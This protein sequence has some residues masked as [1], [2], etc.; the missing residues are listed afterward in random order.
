MKA[1]FEMSD[2]GNLS[3]FLGIEFTKT[4]DGIFMHQR[5]YTYDVLERFQMNG[6][7][8]VSTPIEVG[9]AFDELEEDTSVDKTLDRQ[10]IGCHR[11][12]CNTRPN[13]AYG[14]GLVSR[15]MES[16]KKSNLL[17]ANRILKYVKGTIGHGLMLPTK[18]NNINHNMLGF[19]DADWCIDKSDKKS[20]TSY[21][22]MLGGAPI[23]WCSKKRRC[24]CI[25]LM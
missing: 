16:S 13:I 8:L 6:C 10:M 5:K 14:V 24:G 18:A 21:M 12:V 1:E 25:V 3:Y 19:S 22:F 9:T 7:N 15:Y 20:T 2:L 17:T 11:Y 4:Y 23:S